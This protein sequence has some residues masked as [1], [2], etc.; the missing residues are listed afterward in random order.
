MTLIVEFVDVAQGSCTMAIDS[1]AGAALVVDCPENRD[2]IA[3]A[4]LTANDAELDTVVVSHS[5]LDHLGGVYTLITGRRPS[6]PGRVHYNHDVKL[7]IDPKQKAKMRAALKGLLALED[8]GVQL[9]DAKV[10][11]AGTIGTAGKWEVLS[12]TKGELTAAY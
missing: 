5:D 4:R 1:D 6:L 7:P 2:D 8:D 9:G 10:G 11:D 3:S 12:P